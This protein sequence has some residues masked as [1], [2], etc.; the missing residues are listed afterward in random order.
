MIN[1][2]LENTFSLKHCC[3]FIAWQKKIY[4]FTLA[5]NLQWHE[6][7]HSFQQVCK[8]IHIVDD[9]EIFFKIIYI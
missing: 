2:K 8:F 5:F 7:K 9:D 1:I 4:E 3:K 6:T